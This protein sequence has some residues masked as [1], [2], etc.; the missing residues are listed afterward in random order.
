[1]SENG[2]AP[3]RPHD[4]ATANLATFTALG[5]LALLG[6]GLMALIA[7]ANPFILGVVLV[8]VGFAVLIVLNLLLW[9]VFFG[10]GDGA[11]SL[12]KRWWKFHDDDL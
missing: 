3:R 6:L 4:D 2:P 7:A 11:N 5:L 9:K 1:M 12:W 10:L 8:V